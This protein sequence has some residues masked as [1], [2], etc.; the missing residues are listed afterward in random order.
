MGATSIF[1]LAVAVLS[2]LGGVILIFCFPYIFGRGLSLDDIELG[3]HLMLAT[4][5]NAVI[6][7]GT[8]GFANALI[9][10][11]KFAV[12]RYVSIILIVVIVILFY[13]CL[14]IGFGSIGLAYVQLLT[15]IIGR[16]FYVYYV[17]HVIRLKPKFHGIESSF[18]KEVALYSS[19]I[20]IQMIATQI[21]ASIGQFLIGAVVASSAIYL[22]IYSVG[23]QIIQYYQ[24]IGSAF[25]SVL[26]PG[27]VKLVENEASPQKICDEMVKIGRITFIV[28]GIICGIYAVCGYDFIVLWAG[29]ENSMAFVVSLLLMLVHLFVLVEAVGT[30]VLWAMNAHKEQSFAK[31]FAVLLNIILSVCLI[32]WNVL[33]GAALGTCISLLLGDIILMNI[34]YMKKIKFSL[35]KY[36]SSLLKGILPAIICTV[37][38]GWFICSCIPISWLNLLVKI[39]IMLTIYVIL[40]LVFGFNQYER[41][42]V[43]GILN[44]IK[45]SKNRI[46][47]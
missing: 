2:L 37:I 12:S 46:I 23:M 28:L 41:E 21:N 29:D 6:T 39:L 3:Q 31:L 44:K 36:Y 24:S 17:L 15:T 43:G 20:L 38:L 35:L 16:F 45:H 13:I 32:K 9:A 40:M 10:Y 7:L 1:Y 22:G 27:I 4:T 14:K 33:L 30:Q 5:L 26:M 11:E 42:L 34:I 47:N 18:L 8:A 25:S 19:F